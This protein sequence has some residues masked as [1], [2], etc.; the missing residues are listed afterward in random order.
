MKTLPVALASAAVLSLAAGFSADQVS[1]GSNSAA[2]AKHRPTTF[3]PSK[4][5]PIT[6]IGPVAADVL[7][8]DLISHGSPILTPG[9]LDRLRNGDHI[10]VGS[11]DGHAF[12]MELTET[13]FMGPQQR[14]WLFRGESTGMLYALIVANGDHL[15][16]FV[17]ARDGNSYNLQLGQNGYYLI[18]QAKLAPGAECGTCRYEPKLQPSAPAAGGLAALGIC[19]AEVVPFGLPVGMV[20]DGGTIIDVLV[21]YSIDAAAEAA[22]TGRDIDTMSILAVE[23][24]NLALKNS[25][26][27]TI[28]QYNGRDL[29][30]PWVQNCG[31]ADDD[32]D[33]TTAPLNADET[34]AVPFNA[35]RGMPDDPA[36]C[37]VVSCGGSTT[38]LSG[39]V[40]LQMQAPAEDDIYLPRMRLIAALELDGFFGAEEPYDATGWMLDLDRL[41]NPADG[42]MDYMHIWQN[43]LG[44]DM[45]VMVGKGYQDEGA[46]FAGLASVMTDAVTNAQG[47]QAPP[48]APNA[49]PP[50]KLP[51]NPFPIVDTISA[52]MEALGE[53][54]ILQFGDITATG[55]SG[56]YC[57]IDIDALESLVVAHELGHNMGCQHDHDNVGG[58]GGDG[59]GQRA[60]FP[61][62]FGFPPTSEQAAGSFRTVMAYDGGGQRL[63]G[64]SN[65][66][67]QWSQYL[68]PQDAADAAGL[69][70]DFACDLVDGDETDAA[71]I[72][73]SGVLCDS[74]DTPPDVCTDASDSQATGSSPAC[75]SPDSEIEDAAQ[76]A[77]NNARSIS[78]TKYA[79]ARFR[80]SLTDP[81]D[82]N[83]NEIDDFIEASDGF[84]ED[85]DQ[86]G[87]PDD[88]EVSA[89]PSVPSAADCNANGIPDACDIQYELSQDA[90]NN[91]MPDE[92]E[93]TT[94]VFSESFELLALG[95]K[96]GE[97][98]IAKINADLLSTDG[99]GATVVEYADPDTGVITTFEPRIQPATGD[100]YFA[101]IETVGAGATG[102]GGY[103]YTDSV[104]SAFQFHLG[105]NG[106][107]TLYPTIPGGFAKAFGSRGYGQ[108]L[109]FNGVTGAFPSELGQTTI[110]LA[111]EVESMHL[112]MNAA[113]FTGFFDELPNGNTDCNSPLVPLIPAGLCH[114]ELNIHAYDDLDDDASTTDDWVEV[115]TSVESLNG[116]MWPDVDGVFMEPN[117]LV[118][119]F[120]TAPFGTPDLSF[121]RV[122]ITGAFVVLDNL[123]F[124]MGAEWP[125]CL[126]DCAG[127]TE[128]DGLP[129]PDGTVGAE[130]LLLVL[131][132]FGTSPVNPAGVSGVADLNDDDSVDSM[133][134]A[135]ILATWGPCLSPP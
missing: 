11:P 93:E 5:A 26:V 4:S 47:G 129:T 92:C 15:A 82:C 119:R 49:D 45:V 106:D 118:R 100:A 68:G 84:V 117:C 16:G 22:A 3:A 64:F 127:G 116:L 95:F 113:D 74:N 131:A 54:T 62:S 19:P 72:L 115:F 94:L 42:Y 71:W 66:Q 86:N 98:Y 55:G 87:F 61:D 109:N 73:E 23:L 133:D 44:A 13:G 81:R 130:D 105:L 53:A 24:V 46:G 17:Q 50:L 57:L 114:N 39:H 101:T 12:D 56:P 36:I 69:Q 18:R 77:A 108:M 103:V 128:I 14:K 96:I 10:L 27:Q 107:H 41:Q 28:E 125:T 52:G 8:H 78:Q 38:S 88:C 99:G 20:K 9:A 63:P 126:G 40:T 48:G 123:G 29:N 89:E 134:L 121:D 110:T 33:E 111:T 85:C 2:L 102:E 83:N 91:G 75:G 58:A 79:V 30:N 6:T 43:S 21:V 60:V 90:N 7:D 132:T 112:Q 31:Y 35:G 124:D 97:L 67:R 59:D 32:G 51:A 104:P 70:F 25:A 65:P 80:C 135:E 76:M 122:V 1:G 37:A 34:D 120:I